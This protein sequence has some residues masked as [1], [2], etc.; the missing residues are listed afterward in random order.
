MRKLSFFCLSVC[1]VIVSC[2][3]T[4]S[5]KLEGMAKNTYVTSIK[6]L[7]GGNDDFKVENAKTVFLND[8][9]CI[10][11]MDIISKNKLGG[12]VTERTEYLFFSQNGIYY[13]S[14]HNLDND[15]IYVSQ[16]T[17]Q[18]I[19]KGTIYEN[20]SYEDAIAYRSLLQ[21]DF[22]GREVG[23]SDSEFWLPLPTGTGLWVLDSFTDEFGDKTSHKYLRIVGN[24]TFSNS[25]ATNSDLIAALYV[26]KDEI[27][28][29]FIEYGS[30]VVKDKEYCR[31]KIKDSEGIIHNF[32]FYCY[33][34]GRIKLE[35]NKN[36]QYS[37]E[38]KDL[39]ELEGI[40]SV[41]AVMGKYSQSDYK[42]KLNINGYKKALTYL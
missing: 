30:S 7:T 17:L 24:G 16:Q 41:N 5:S 11:H 19:K 12:E 8:S 28:F 42:F 31:I 9:L 14:F 34:S 20:L 37:K 26:D 13:E 33:K 23:N 27:Y 18:K 40:I 3:E 36:K 39:M 32:K 35:D 38:L 25:A 10:L 6:Q 29:K 21:I 4:P 22:N 15:S 1:F 2:S